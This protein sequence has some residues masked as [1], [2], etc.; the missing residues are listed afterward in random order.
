MD[1][2]IVK[3]LVNKSNEIRNF[4]IKTVS[5]TG[6]H[7]GA[8]LGTVEFVVAAH[9]I[10]KL[11]NL[12]DI[13]IFDT[14]H[15]GYVHKILTGRKK[16]F[17][18]LNKFRGMSRFLTP[19]ES[20]FDIIE[21]SHAGTALSIA[22]GISETNYLK[23][24]KQEILVVMGDGALNEGMNFEALN[25]LKDCK[26]KIIIIFND[27]NY[28]IDKSV[29]SIKYMSENFITKKTF[30]N[31]FSSLGLDYLLVRDGHDINLLLNQFKKA[32]QNKNHTVVHIK[33]TKGKG[34]EIAKK[35][36]YKLHFSEALN[37]KTG[38]TIFKPS[39][40]NNFNFTTAKFIEALMKKDKRI[41]LVTPATPYTNFLQEISD[42][43]KD[44]II[45]VGM[46]E[47]HAVGFSIGLSMRGYK[48][49]CFFQ[50]TFMQRAFDQFLHDVGY[51]KSNVLFISA[52]SGLSGLDSPTH[53][54]IYDL[55]YLQ[56]IPNLDII[57]P[58]CMNT[59]KTE[60]LGYLQKKTG[61]KLLLM[62][63][64]EIPNFLKKYKF[65]KKEGYYWI[66][67]FSNKRNK[68]KI[69]IFCLINTLDICLVVSRELL[70]KNINV[71]LVCIEKIKKINKNL[72]INNS[73]N[74]LMSCTVE[75]NN[76]ING[77]G[78]NIT[79]IF[80]ENN[81]KMYNLKIGFND[82]YVESGKREDILDN[83]NLN[84]K[85]I[86]IKIKE[87]INVLSKK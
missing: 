25:H 1:K 42:K 43:Y 46:A 71:K 47:Q 15:Q 41:I 64:Y 33:T 16:N 49:I 85:K 20:K 52:R 21:A 82:C 48:P 8:N 77:L 29:G 17:S 72:I 58:A 56:A 73:K 18:N 4:L 78:Y 38:K 31:F 34:L 53:H 6:G 69:T 84:P 26:G 81:L 22:N 28:F 30:K 51:M 75:E 83:S 35:H 5:K 60:V 3:N 86:L 67:N 76:L 79:N 65:I 27:N 87:K 9:A 66:K 7:L 45:D 44:R 62:P 39:V 14:G 2:I 23:K 37:I 68:K 12:K 61:P 32:K 40:K 57:Y 59:V 50:S 10:F 74:S 55:S 11:K 19:Q 63:Y 70:K 13:M 54:G 36:K 80:N 24:K